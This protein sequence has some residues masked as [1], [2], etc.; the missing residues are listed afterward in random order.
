MKRLLIGVS[1]FAILAFL[2]ASFNEPDK[3]PVNDTN[4]VTTSAKEQLISYQIIKRDTL[5]KFKESYDIRVDLVE[6]RLPNEKEL[7]AVSATLRNKSFDKTFICFYLPGMEV[8]AGAFATAHHDPNPQAAKINLFMVPPKFKELASATDATSIETD[9]GFPETLLGNWQTADGR[10]MII[11]GNELTHIL[12]KSTFSQSVARIDPIDGGYRVVVIENGKEF[13]QTWEV[14]EHQFSIISPRGLVGLLGSPYRKVRDPL[15][16]WTDNTGTFS[17]KA[18]FTSYNNGTVLF[19]K[20]DG[21]E[22][23]VPVGQLSEAD[24]E[25]LRELFQERGVKASF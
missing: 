16:T 22:I 9:K 8:D 20:E 3:G 21:T 10:R 24:K 14:T 18:E 17:V 2:L 6:G 23:K 19:R 4:E 1:A 11:R 13:P 12:P 15:R 7:E 25:F 5:R